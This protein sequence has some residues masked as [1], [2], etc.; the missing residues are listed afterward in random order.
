VAKYRQGKK[1]IDAHGDTPQVRKAL[2]DARGDVAKAERTLAAERESLAAQQRQAPT[3][4]RDVAEPLEPR[5]SKPITEPPPKPAPT[6]TPP[7]PAPT[8]TPTVG[9]PARTVAEIERELQ[10]KG[11][12]PGVL[13]KFK[14]EA[15]RMTAAVA[16]RVEKLMEHLTPDDV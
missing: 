8:K 11:L 5:P 16:K 10:T 12:E 1:F 13:R 2:G 7:K 6:G 4:R 9:K 14:G 3:T 15:K